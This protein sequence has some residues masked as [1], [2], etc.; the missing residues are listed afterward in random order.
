MDAAVL[1]R[2]W[3]PPRSISAPTAASRSAEPPGSSTRPPRWRCPPPWS[4]CSVAA[5]SPRS[6]RGRAGPGAHRALRMVESIAAGLDAGGPPHS[7]A[8]ARCRSSIRPQLR[9]LA[10]GGAGSGSGRVARGV[11]GTTRLPRAYPTVSRLRRAP[12]R[13]AGRLEGGSLRPR[14]PC[15]AR[16]V[17]DAESGV[18]P[19]LR[20]R[21]DLGGLATEPDHR[22]SWSASTVLDEV[23]VERARRLDVPLQTFPAAELENPFHVV[24]TRRRFTSRL[25]E[26]LMER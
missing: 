7:C 10:L 25:A 22:R 26:Q 21:S 12:P 16:L 17:A 23:P 4:W 19:R 2:H 5:R 20:R 11:D 24:R 15:G 9:G 13:G 14:A 3:A 6:G 8:L 1:A 18:R